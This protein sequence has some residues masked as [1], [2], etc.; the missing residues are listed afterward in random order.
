MITKLAWRN[1]WRNPVRSGVVIGAVGIG[2]WAAIAI[3]GFATGM[4]KSY[5]DNAITSHISHIQIHN[6][7]YK[8]EEEVTDFLTN[9]REVL[10]ILD[11]TQEVQAYAARTMVNGML[12]SPKG[13]RGIKIKGVIPEQEKAVIR[14]DEMM[15]EGSYFEQK[16]KNELLISERLAEKLKV[17]VRNKVV[18]TFQDLDGDITAGAFRIVGVFDTGNNP[19]DDGHVFVLQKDLIRLLTANN[20]EIETDGPLVHEIALLLKSTDKLEAVADRL[21]GQMPA[22]RVET[23][24]QVSPDLELYESQ[25]DTISLVY[26]VIIM[27]ALVFGIINTMLMAVLER[28]RETGMLMA[29]GMNKPKIFFMIVL[30]TLFLSLVAMPIGL[31]LGYATIYYVGTYGL[32][33]SAFS[34]SL[35]DFGMSDRIYF[36]VEPV[37]YQQ[38]PVV[39]GITAI[40]ASIYPA[41]KAI[42]M[43][44]VEAIRKI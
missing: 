33:L 23:Y 32:D 9:S 22:Q 2:I 41:F 15:V 34:E 24:R 36:A 37:V 5:V 20:G 14:L 35:Q 17:G 18:L 25:M 30:E 11:N 1:I 26:L 39:L 16:R 4:M 38:V 8:G 29:I 21:S 10:N 43:R 42:R 6:P 27:L 40:L 44:P 13:A 7:D 3:S 28:V 12:S 31:L 19:F